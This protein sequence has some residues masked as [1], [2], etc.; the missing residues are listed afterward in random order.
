MGTKVFISYRR[1][2]SAGYAGRLMDYLKT[3]LGRDLLFMDVETIPLGSN[4][5]KVLHEEIS[6]CLVLLAV[7]GPTWCDARDENGKRRLDDPNDFVRMEIS[8]ALQRDIP[9]IPILL[10]GAT[11]PKADQLPNALRGLTSRN[12]LDVRHGSFHEDIDRLVRSLK[13]QV[14]QS[15]APRLAKSRVSENRNDAR[16]KGWLWLGGG[17]VVAAI[18]AWAATVYFFPLERTRTPQLPSPK[19]E[20]GP[21]GVAIGGDVKGSTITVNPTAGGDSRSR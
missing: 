5:E 6:K 2:D 12:G 8:A 14:D 3:K 1:K 13:A 10:D 7:I 18:G 20:A 21:G 11:M 4:F 17:L 15:S 19:V 16:A 9:V